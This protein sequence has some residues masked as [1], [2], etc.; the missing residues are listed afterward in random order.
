M[1]RKD[2]FIK[3]I[4][5]LTKQPESYISGR[6][7]L[8]RGAMPGGDRFDDEL[9]DNEAQNLLAGLR[10]DKSGVLTWLMQGRLSFLLKHSEPAGRA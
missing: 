5:E 4:S 3:I 6:V 7:D 10:K 8:I 9:S 2:I 1:T